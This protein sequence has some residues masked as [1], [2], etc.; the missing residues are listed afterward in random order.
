MA[1]SCTCGIIHA[2]SVVIAEANHSL[3]YVI[4]DILR[5]PATGF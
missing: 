5:R 2:I 3:T 1:W 4:K